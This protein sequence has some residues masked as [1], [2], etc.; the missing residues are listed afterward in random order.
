MPTRIKDTTSKSGLASGLTQTDPKWM[1]RTA[2][3]GKNG[4]GNNL[5]PNKGEYG[6]GLN[7]PP[8]KMSRSGGKGPGGSTFKLFHEGPATM[9]RSDKGSASH[10]AND[11][12]IGGVAGNGGTGYGVGGK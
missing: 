2:G 4:N 5:P 1:P 7:S 8:T 10:R 12:G 11:Y 3:K 6:L 9:P